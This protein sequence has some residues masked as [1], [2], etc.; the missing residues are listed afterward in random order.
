MVAAS[1]FKR[2]A[3]MAARSVS[4]WVRPSGELWIVKNH[5][6]PA[7]RRGFEAYSAHSQY[8]LIAA[9]YLAVAAA[10]ADESIPEGASP[11]DVGGYV[12][13]LPELHKVFANSGGHYVEIDTG[14]DTAYDSTGLM[15]I[16]RRGMDNA[17]GPTGNAPASAS[18]LALGI[19]WPAAKGGWESLAQ[20]GQG[21]V[22]AATTVTSA[23]P[24]KVEFTVR[25]ELAGAA[26][27]SVSETYTLQPDVLTVASRIDGA[28]DRWKLAFPAF[29]DD[30]RDRGAITVAPDGAEVR[31]GSSAQALTIATE[32]AQLLGAGRIGQ[33]RGGDYE[34]IEW[35]G[36]GKQV[37][38]RVGAPAWRAL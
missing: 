13:P 22:R 34:S 24:D 25:Y 26:V 27:T 36:P 32:H 21:K 6:D 28:A 33:M 31:V 3:R 38:Y 10:A 35:S 17:I 5:Y 1:A 14:A 23:A 30:G 12:A 19:A 7:V 18:A 37:T 9:A 20:F 8:N 4:R 16:H 2:A 15:R 29:L 11:A